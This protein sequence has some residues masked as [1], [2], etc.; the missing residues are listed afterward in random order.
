MNIED[1]VKH[2]QEPAQKKTIEDVIRITEE[3]SNTT[4]EFASIYICG[5]NI[6]VRQPRFVKFDDDNVRNESLLIAR[7]FP[8]GRTE[9]LNMKEWL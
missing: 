7:C 1:I 3:L 9:R 8:G 4:E 6:Y 2:W 5:F